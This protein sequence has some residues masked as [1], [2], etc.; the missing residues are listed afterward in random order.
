MSP[1]PTHRSNEPDIGS[2]EKTKG[3]HETEKMISQVN[4]QSAHPPPK[5]PGLAHPT[6]P[7]Q[8]GEDKH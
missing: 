1:E 7:A 5:G 8:P 2:G 6:G 4:D 3:Q